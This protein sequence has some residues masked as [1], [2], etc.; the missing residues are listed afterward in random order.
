MPRIVHEENLE[1]GEFYQDIFIEIGRVNM[2]QIIES[3]SS[4]QLILNNLLNLMTIGH[5]NQSSERIRARYQTSFWKTFIQYFDK[6][7]SEAYRF[8]KIRHFEKV[9]LRLIDIVLMNLTVNSED[10]FMEFNFQDTG[11]ENFDEYFKNKRDLGKLIRESARLI[12]RKEIIQIISA[13]L[14]VGVI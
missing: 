3:E 5:Q 13:K 1:T 10:T 6:F 14:E 8:E 7:C 2:K 11:E 12:G 4:D 9:F